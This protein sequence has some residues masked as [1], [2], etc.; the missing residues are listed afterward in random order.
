MK[1]VKIDYFF[2]IINLRG[3]IMFGENDK[4]YLSVSNAINKNGEKYIININLPNDFSTVSFPDDV[5]KVTVKEKEIRENNKAYNTY[6]VL[7]GETSTIADLDD[8]DESIA[9]SKMVEDEDCIK[10]DD[11][12]C[13]YRDED[14]YCV[15]FAKVQDTD[16]V[17]RNIEELENKL[18]DISTEFKKIQKSIS[19]IKRYVYKK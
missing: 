8:N 7:I 13:Y 4:V 18:N 14:D 9:L 17:V 3:D 12:I 6:N 1:I 10:L 15:I 2:V 5:I 19:K 16:I 11:K